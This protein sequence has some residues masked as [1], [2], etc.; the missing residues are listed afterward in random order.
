MTEIPPPARPGLF[1]DKLQ[2]AWI[3]AIVLAL[4]ATAFL[5][6]PRN[7]G[8]D[9]S[10]ELW[11]GRG[12]ARVPPGWEDRRGF[13][14][15]ARVKDFHAVVFVG[16]SIVEDWKGLEEAFPKVRTANRG[17]AGDLSR[18]VLARLR[19]DVLELNPRAVVLLIGTNDLKLGG[20]PADVA[21]NIGDILDACAAA[22]PGTPV[23]LCELLPRAAEAGLFPD[24]ILELNTL[25]A[26]VVK[27]RRNVILC[28]TFAALAA[29]DGSA[30]VDLFP[31]GLH[32]DAAGYAKLAEALAPAFRRAGLME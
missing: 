5:H 25:L 6:W 14:R 21:A 8:P 4:A 22:H 10:P 23:I 17:I 31:D 11:P 3:A 19:E 1:H 28:E 7:G 26:S 9:S 30:P 27:P 16:D 18:G 20:S 32:P 12:P 15:V 2:V 24:K 29:A 13:F